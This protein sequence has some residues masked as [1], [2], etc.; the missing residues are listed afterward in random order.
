MM[1]IIKKNTRI[2]TVDDFKRTVKAG[3]PAL[4]VRQLLGGTAL[5]TNCFFGWFVWNKTFFFFLFLEKF[6]Y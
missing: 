5:K 4:V 1:V 6:A 3:V 2:V